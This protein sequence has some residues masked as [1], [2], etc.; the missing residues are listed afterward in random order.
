MTFPGVG[1]H[2]QRVQSRDAPRCSCMRAIPPRE[3]FA[4]ERRRRDAERPRQTIGKHHRR[5]AGP[6][7]A[8]VRA[9]ARRSNVSADLKC[10]CADISPGSA[11]LRKKNKKLIYGYKGGTYSS[12]GQQEGE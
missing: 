10:G 6:V 9:C 5:H 12:S 1:C 2:S 7:R 4:P 8:C 3:A 11:A